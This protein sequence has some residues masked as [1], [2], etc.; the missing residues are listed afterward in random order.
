MGHDE[1]ASKQ[2]GKHQDTL[3][4]RLDREVERTARAGGERSR[5]EL[6]RRD[7]ERHKGGRK[8]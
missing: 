6:I 8:R 4:G 5:R 3:R 7:I 1:D 2:H